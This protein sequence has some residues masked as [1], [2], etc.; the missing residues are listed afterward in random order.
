MY[1]NWSE[2]WENNLKGLVAEY[3]R[4]MPDAG[5]ILREVHEA[6]NLN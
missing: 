4:G 2:L 3:L 6:Y 5:D 1:G